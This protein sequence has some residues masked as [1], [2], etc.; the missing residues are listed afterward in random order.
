MI[1]IPR[2]GKRDTGKLSPAR[3]HRPT[4]QDQSLAWL[5][6]LVWGCHCVNHCSHN[7]PLGFRHTT[8]LSQVAKDGREFLFL[9]HF[10]WQ[11]PVRNILRRKDVFG[12][13]VSKGLVHVHVA[14]PTWT[15]SLWQRLFNSPPIGKEKGRDWGPGINVKH[16]PLF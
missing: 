9:P 7:T 13:L 11:R 1:P 6:G 3:G 2:W 10:L 12:F 16:T 14:P 4:F 5:Q 8:A 15:E